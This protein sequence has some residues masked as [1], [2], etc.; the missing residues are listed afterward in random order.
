MVPA[1]GAN[2]VW[3]ARRARLRA[4]EV[5]AA[6]AAEAAEAELH[7]VAKP[8]RVTGTPWCRI[9]F[10]DVSGSDHEG[11]IVNRTSTGDVYAT[12]SDEEE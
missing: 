6:L 9:Q 8:L 12:I 1:W 7:C 11:P 3:R 4:R 5:D 2:M 10:V